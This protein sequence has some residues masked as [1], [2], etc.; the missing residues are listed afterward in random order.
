[1]QWIVKKGDSLSL[2]AY[3]T[4]F[5]QEDLM[6]LNHLDNDKILIGQTIRLPHKDAP[7]TYV[8]N[9]GDSLWN[10]AQEFNTTPEAISRLNNLNSSTIIPGTILKLPLF[11][12][13]TRGINVLKAMFSN[14]K[15]KE[16]GPWFNDKS[17]KKTQ[18]SLEYG[19][20]S[21]WSTVESYKKAVETK[22]IL[23]REIEMAGKL[24]RDLKGWTIVLDPGHGGL[25]PGAI[26]ESKDGQGNSAFVVEDEYAYDI[27]IRVY[28]LLKQ[29]GGDADLTIISPNHH[30]RHTPDASLTFVNEKNEVY[31]SE[32]LNRTGSWSEWPVGG[33]EGLEKRLTVTKEIINREKNRNNIFISIHCDNT[34]GGFLQSGILIWGDSNEEKERGR[35][36]A[37]AFNQTFPAGLDIKEQPLHVLGGNPA[38]GGAILVEIRN[39]HYDNNSWALRN[40][41][42][43]DADAEKIVESIRQFAENY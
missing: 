31:N 14:Q 20:L 17:D 35:K 39:L 25:D 9:R 30:V 24:S 26:V 28:A 1:L 37:E 15:E 3:E 40:E 38:E 11:T 27:A 19:E 16:T 41:D 32:S 8:V 4:G 21:K 5:S 10:I 23:D 43:R 18:L 6:I 36:L 2:I 29:H 42:L 12:S 33:S 34:P 7:G 13:V 22:K